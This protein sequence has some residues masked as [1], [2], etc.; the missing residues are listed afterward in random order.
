MVINY[1]Y[2]KAVSAFTYPPWQLQTARDTEQSSLCVSIRFIDFYLL[3][4][5][6]SGCFDVKGIWLTA[7]LAFMVT[8]LWS[9]PHLV[10][11]SE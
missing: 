11:V 9:L 2:S 6:A 1:P 5:P 10:G 4:V 3:N 8:K 7:D